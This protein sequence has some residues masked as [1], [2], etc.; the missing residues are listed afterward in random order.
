[1][2]G[3]DGKGPGGAFQRQKGDPRKEGGRVNEGMN[4][5]R[6]KDL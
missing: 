2:K 4:L 3:K 6:R 1:M 5:S